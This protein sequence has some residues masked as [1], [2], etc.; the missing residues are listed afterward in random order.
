[1]WHTFCQIY[2]WRKWRDD[3]LARTEANLNPLAGT[4]GRMTLDRTEA[5]LD[6]HPTE[7]FE[8]MLESLSAR[9]LARMRMMNRRIHDIV[10]I[11]AGKLAA[12]IINRERSRLEASMVRMLRGPFPKPN[13]CATQK[14]SL[15]GLRRLS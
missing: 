2:I 15:A 10:E 9:E 3:A 1:M 8:M 13:P 7:I 12:N 6:D 11:Q 4:L 14:A 5:S